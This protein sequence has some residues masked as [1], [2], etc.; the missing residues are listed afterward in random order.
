MGI[1]RVPE[2]LATI[3]ERLALLNSTPLA[4]LVGPAYSIVQ[5]QRSAAR[6]AESRLGLACHGAVHRDRLRCEEGRAA[7]EHPA[8]LSPRSA[9]WRWIHLVLL[10]VPCL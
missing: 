9:A 2:S 6:G 8:I 3:H 4:P 10:G 1:F 7:I 5:G